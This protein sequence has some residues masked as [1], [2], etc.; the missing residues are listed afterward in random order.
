LQA[1]TLKE[2]FSQLFTFGDCGEPLCLTV[3]AAVHG[4]HYIPSVV[5]GENNLLGFLTGA[6]GQSIG[7]LPFTAASSGVAFTFEGGV[8]VPVPIS[9][10]PIFAE[11][12]ETLGRGRAFVSAT[13]NGIAFD[14]VRGVPLSNLNFSFAHQNVGNA[15]M[16]DPSFENDVI[17]VATDLKLSLLVTSIVGTYGLTDRIDIGVALPIVRASLSGTSE[18]EVN[19][20]SDP[21]PHSF[22]TQGNPTPM[23]S[24]SAEGS[25]LGLGDIAL[26]MKV[27]VFQ[28][29]QNSFSIV[30]DV[31]LPTGNE[32]DFLG[33]GATIVRVF[34]VAS[35]RYGDF[36]PHVNA[37]YLHTNAVDQ[38]NRFLGALGFD[39]LV[40]PQFT[41]FGEL[42]ASVENG[43]SRLRLPEPV[44]YTAPAPRTLELTEIPD[45]KDNFFDA[46]FGAKYSAGNDLRILANVLFPLAKAGVR[47]TMLWTLG[48][49]RTF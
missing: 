22:G 29:P 31:R 6:I 11:R 24:A 21:S 9:P 41:I 19:Q 37:A 18:A 34:G 28:T 46:S 7:N 17:E 36:T 49:E 48:L 20:F 43:E 32:D 3:N 10:G 42:L 25:A 27:N 1:Q 16:G 35:A 33:S 26:R 8:P 44:V 38:N 14:N 2:R 39:Q 13:L 15:A 4:D 12:A 23:A 40:S 45:R 5:Q 47:P 30:G